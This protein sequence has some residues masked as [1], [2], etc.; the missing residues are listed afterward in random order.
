MHCTVTFGG[1]KTWLHLVELKLAL[2]SYCF[3]K[4]RNESFN[5]ECDSLAEHGL[6]ESWLS[7]EA[8]VRR[9]A[10]MTYYLLW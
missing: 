6:P 5:S 4:P 8:I 3:F 7:R 1:T 10:V 2:V 9:L